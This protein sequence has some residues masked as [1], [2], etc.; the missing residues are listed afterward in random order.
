MCQTGR[1]QIGV[2]CAARACCEARLA[3]VSRHQ[4]G[5]GTASSYA[6]VIVPVAMMLVGLFAGGQREPIW[7]RSTSTTAPPAPPDSTSTGHAGD[8]AA[9]QP[10]ASPAMP[11]D[12]GITKRCRSTRLPGQF[13]PQGERTH[14]RAWP[15][16]TWLSWRKRRF[17]RCQTVRKRP[18]CSAPVPPP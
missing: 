8:A 16:A 11:E 17:R 9:R 6:A 1:P 2:I 15:G 4:R 5:E 18:A 14:V 13:R 7:T 10:P 12:S 3:Q